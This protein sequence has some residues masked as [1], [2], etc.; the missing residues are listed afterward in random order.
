MKAD[1][2]PRHGG[3]HTPRGPL[4]AAQKADKEL[5]L[6]LTD[7]QPVDVDV[8]DERLLIEDARKAVEELDQQGL[9]S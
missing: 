2:R 1:C 4:R 8:H 9:F 7:G 5:L 3:G 6:L